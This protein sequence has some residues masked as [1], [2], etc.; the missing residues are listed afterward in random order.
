M[1]RASGHTRSLLIVP[2]ARSRWRYP[3]PARSFGDVSKAGAAGL[4]NLRGEPRYHRNAAVLR[5]ET[6]STTKA[7]IVRVLL[8]DDGPIRDT[9][10]EHIG[11]GKVKRWVGWEHNAMLGFIREVAAP[12]APPVLLAAPLG[13]PDAEPH[14]ESVPESVTES[15]AT[16]QVRPISQPP[17]H[18]RAAY[19]TFAAGSAQSLPRGSR[20]AAGLAA[21]AARPIVEVAAGSHAAPRGAALR[22]DPV[23]GADQRGTAK[24]AAHL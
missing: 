16:T 12:A 14:P 4:R 7:S 15:S 17:C 8:N 9:R 11:T 5:Q 19:R 18:R 3:A 1:R 21:R 10:M 13:P 23:P 6:G 2:S 22:G 24:R 20:P